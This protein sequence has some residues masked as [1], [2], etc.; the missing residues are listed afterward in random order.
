MMIAVAML[1]G[2]RGQSM[3][4][5]RVWRAKLVAKG[6]CGQEDSSGDIARLQDLRT[7]SLGEDL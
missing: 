6:R 5:A 7:C 2:N 1:A 3:K 4:D